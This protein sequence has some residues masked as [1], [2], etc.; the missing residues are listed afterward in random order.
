MSLNSEMRSS[1]LASVM[2]HVI[3]PAGFATPI[4]DAP[5][6]V[7]TL[8]P[9]RVRPNKHI[10]NDGRLMIASKGAASAAEMQ[11]IKVVDRRAGSATASRHDFQVPLFARRPLGSLME[12]A[13]CTPMIFDAD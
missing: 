12:F 11:S 10:V 9:T 8:F 1:N 2:F 7:A 5:I 6:S 4:T 3:K 13:R